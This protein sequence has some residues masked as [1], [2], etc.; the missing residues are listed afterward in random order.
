LIGIA[1]SND[2]KET[3]ILN[4]TRFALTI[5]VTEETAISHTPDYLVYS[6]T[7]LTILVN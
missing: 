6:N 7:F 1:L 5:S 3:I 2:K 4:I